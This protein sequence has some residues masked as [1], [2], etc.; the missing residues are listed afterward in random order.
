[1]EH[2]ILYNHTKESDQQQE[3]S[4]DIFAILNTNFEDAWTSLQQPLVIPKKTEPIIN[5]H[6]DDHLAEYYYYCESFSYRLWNGIFIPVASLAHEKERLST[7]WHGIIGV[8]FNS[9]KYCT[10]CQK[11]TDNLDD[12]GYCPACKENIYN[13]Q[14]CCRIVGAGKPFQA[15]CDIKNPVCGDPERSTTIC[16]KNH[17]VYILRINSVLKVGTSM[18]DRG[19]VSNGYLYRILE[20]GA[21]EAWV[22]INKKTKK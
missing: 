14:H 13:K 21:D 10:S 9:A 19:Q 22:W 6:S 11:N 5:I 3:L 18:Q 17:I 8:K 2:Q 12:L 15:L 7:Y 4:D 16:Q 20:Q 1:M